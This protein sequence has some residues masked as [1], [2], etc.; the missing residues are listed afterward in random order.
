[1]EVRFVKREDI[2]KLFISVSKPYQAVTLNTASRWIKLI[3]HASGIN[4][5]L[6]T[7]GSTRAASVSKA[8][9]M[10][11]PIETILNAAGWSRKTTFSRFYDR[12][13]VKTNE[14]SDYIMSQ[15]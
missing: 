9:E 4:V 14:L 2:D 6:A 13:I 1:M 3:L 11:A 15:K 5:G 12:E 7:A 10:G 8:K